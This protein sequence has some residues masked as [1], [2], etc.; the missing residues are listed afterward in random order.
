MPSSHSFLFIMRCIF[1]C[2]IANCTEKE[3]GV[4][5]KRN[6]CVCV[7]MFLLSCPPLWWPSLAYLAQK[8]LAYLICLDVQ[9]LIP[10]IIIVFL[11]IFLCAQFGG[12]TLPKTFHFASFEWKSTVVYLSSDLFIIWFCSAAILVYTIYICHILPFPWQVWFHN[13]EK[14]FPCGVGWVSG[15][16]P[17]YATWHPCC[18]HISLVL[19][20]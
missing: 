4:W 16:C 6:C 19:V 7:S 5:Q 12:H 15:H 14:L 20:L 2:E 13:L 17:T 9:L 11:I 18:M 10:G 8:A 1:L 3:R